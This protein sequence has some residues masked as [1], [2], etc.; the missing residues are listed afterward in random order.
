M[1]GSETTAV[2]HVAPEKP[3]THA[4]V[5]TGLPL[6]LLHV[7]ATTL[8]VTVHGSLGYLHASG[9]P[10]HAGPVKPLMHEHVYKALVVEAV[11]VPPFMHTDGETAHGFTGTIV[12]QVGPVKPEMQAHANIPDEV[13]E[14]TP[15]LLQ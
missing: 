15:K 7:C 12:A 8:A 10:P 13:T 14:Q 6:T 5:H 2:A 9:A 11:Q 4:Y 3:A 1:Q